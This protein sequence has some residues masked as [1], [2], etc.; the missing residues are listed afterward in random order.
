MYAPNTEEKSMITDLYGVYGYALFSYCNSLNSMS[1]DAFNTHASSSISMAY[2]MF[3]KNSSGSDS[4]GTNNYGVYLNAP[5]SV[6]GGATS[7]EISNTPLYA[8]CSNTYFPTTIATLVDKSASYIEAEVKLYR[9]D[10]ATTLFG[11]I[12]EQIRNMYK[13]GL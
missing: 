10:G 4:F 2:G 1:G 3:Y 9:M 6:S 13:N 5:T 11:G 8:R 12:R 7:L